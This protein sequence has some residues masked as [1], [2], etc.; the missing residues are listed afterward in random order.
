MLSTVWKLLLA[1]HL[2]EL[3]CQ[4]SV[5]HI[6][7]SYFVNFVYYALLLSHFRKDTG[8]DVDVNAIYDVV[9][10]LLFGKSMNQKFSQPFTVG[11][12]AA[13]VLD[14]DVKVLASLGPEEFGTAFVWAY[15]RSVNFLS[16]SSQMLLPLVFTRESWWTRAGCL[17]S[18]IP[19]LMVNTSLRTFNMTQLPLELLHLLNSSLSL[20]GFLHEL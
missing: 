20:L 11:L 13:V 4:P 12:A 19:T 9:C 17:I 16:S 1:E 6:K 2:A 8:W 7:K 5:Y 18:Y 14:L 10:N 15:K 3:W